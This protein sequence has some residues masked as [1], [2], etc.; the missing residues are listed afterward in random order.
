MVDAL[1]VT[2]VEGEREETTELTTVG[3]FRKAA[4]I[5]LD[6]LRTNSDSLM[7]V[8]EAFVHDPL[9]EWTKS[10]S[11]SLSMAGRYAQCP[12]SIGPKPTATSG[13]QLIAT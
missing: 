6:L 3:V 13:S 12:T 2:G 9:V 10:V 11:T 1:G 5:T 4:E 7:S 8:L